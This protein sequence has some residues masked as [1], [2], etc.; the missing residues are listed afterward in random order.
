MAA[1]MIQ[2]IGFMLSALGVFLISAATAMDMW[3]LQDRSFTIVTNV[4]TYS[5]LW[6]SC[7]GT[8]Y[9]TTQCRPYFTILGLPGKRIT[10]GE[11]KKGH[12]YRL[13][14]HMLDQGEHFPKGPWKV[15]QNIWEVLGADVLPFPPPPHLLRRM[16][17]MQSTAKKDGVSPES[18]G[19]LMRH[20]KLS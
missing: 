8:S 2:L 4:Y 18:N 15:L 16:R 11:E 14:L 7:V 3:S 17:K 12:V 20:P 5:G 1:S 13:F 6:N 19:N 10:P 9:G